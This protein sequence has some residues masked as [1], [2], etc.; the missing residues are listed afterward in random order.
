M[1][2]RLLFVYF[3][4]A[5]G[6]MGQSETGRAVLEGAV[7]D[8]SGKT[9]AS[10]DIVIRETQTGLQRALKTNAEGAF[11]ASALP[12]GLYVVEATF[13]GFG[14]SRVTNIAL[15][16]GETKT[17]NITLQVSSLSTQVTVQ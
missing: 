12:V 13:Q 16:V 1:Q 8:T 7:V 15:T 5:F 3:A 17:T 2:T 4:I 11:R 14:T 9:I 6:L 10:A